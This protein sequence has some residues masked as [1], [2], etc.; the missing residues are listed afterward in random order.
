M[1]NNQPTDPP[2]DDLHDKVMENKEINKELKRREE[3]KK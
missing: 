3:G 1:I 2:P